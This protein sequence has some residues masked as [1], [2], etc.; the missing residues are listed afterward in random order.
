[1]AAAYEVK[2]N[3]TEPLVATLTDASG[4]VVLPAGTVVRFGMK[5]VGTPT[6]TVTGAC[7]VLDDGTAGLRGKVRYNWA[8]TDLAVPG[9]YRAEFQATFPSGVRKTFPSS[10]WLDLIVY[11]EIVTA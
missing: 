7:T 10:G 5:T 9:V 2:Q 8:G 11:P 4:A 3:D 6:A 1:M